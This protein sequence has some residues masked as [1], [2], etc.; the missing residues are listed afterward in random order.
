[1]RVWDKPRR[2]RLAVTAVVALVAVLLLSSGNVSVRADTGDGG[3]AINARLVKPDEIA[4]GLDG[5]IYIADSEDFRVRRVDPDGIITTVAGTGVAGYNGDGGQASEAQIEAPYGID[6]GP[7]GTL[8]I[9]DSANFRIRHVDEFGVISTVAGNG[10]E[11]YSGDNGP[12]T[13]ATMELAFGVAVDLDGGFY[14]SD[15]F[16]QVIRHVD[17][18][19]TITTVAGIGSGG[20]SGDFGPATEAALGDPYSIEAGDD[21]S[22][23]I[24]DSANFRVRRV[25]PGGEIVTVAGDGTPDYGGDGGQATDAQIGSMRDV[26]VGD[27]GNLYIA[28]TFNHAIRR[29]GTDGIITT[30]AGTGEAGFSGDGGAAVDA[31]LA[32]PY[33]VTPG[34]DGE[35]FIAD[36]D[37]HRVRRIGPSGI[38]QTIAGGEGAIPVPA[39]NSSISGKVEDSEGDPLANVCAEA[40][41]SS[42]YLAGSALTSDSGE[43]TIKEL[44]ADTYR[45]EFSDC[46]DGHASEW[47]NDKPSLAAADQINVPEGSDVENIDATL[48]QGGSISGTVTGAGVAK[49]GLCVDAYTTDGSLERTAATDG[50]GHYQVVGLA[51][52]GYK[53][54]FKDCRQTAAYMSEWTGGGHDPASAQVV[55]VVGTSDTPGIDA[56]LEEGGAISGKVRDDRSTLLADAC[57]TAYE[58]TGVV[59]GSASTG[60]TGL[61]KVGALPDGSYKVEFS[62]CLSPATHIPSWSGGSSSYDG[63]SPIAVSVGAETKNVDGVIAEGGSL[64]GVVITATGQPLQYVCVDAYTSAS[65]VSGSGFTDAAGQ[66]SIGGLAVG[67][68]RVFFRDCSYPASYTAEWYTRKPDFASANVVSVT[69]GEETTGVSAILSGV[70]LKQGDTDCDG[71]FGE[72]DFVFLLRFAA[73]L[74]DGTAPRGCPGLGDAVSGSAFAWGDVNCDNHVNALDA[75]FEVAHKAGVTP[76]P[77]GGNCVP[78][79][80]ALT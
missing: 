15:A 76:P 61:Y 40:Y 52:G 74:N 45:I 32:R 1:M 12:A 3:L 30:I 58:A 56:S 70:T 75:L 20:F 33:G 37:N 9:A 60:P 19:G 55:N 44:A 49:E 64:S 11:G 16:N 23:Y 46:T 79:G 71:L 34:A 43:Y 41:D 68:H 62:D 17:P 4:I 31:Q 54:Q 2:F 38:I 63:A 69:V 36:A 22:F 78:I 80:S 25:S 26:A 10:G 24:G 50:Q 77:I 5:S 73:E 65:V 66:Y 35:I 28:D 8:Y 53:L 48:P 21:G 67:Q 57:V 39:R 51:A 42:S 6:I 59:A 29:V 27:D 18:G 7:D 13:D 47:Y 72:G 14:I